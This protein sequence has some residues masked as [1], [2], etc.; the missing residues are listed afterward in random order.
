MKRSF[1]LLLALLLAIFVS[2]SYSQTRIVFLPFQNMDGNMNLN[3][4]CYKL[5]D[6]LAK[7]FH[8][9]D[10]EG[11][12]YRIIPS[13]SVKAQLAALKL[14]PTSPQYQ[15]DIWKVVEELKGTLVI[16]GNFLVKADRFLICAYIYDVE[17]KMPNQDFQARDLFVSEDK[18]FN[19]IPVI[20]RKLFTY[21][22]DGK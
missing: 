10:P 11:K 4:W 13:D 2:N 7:S 15:T 3:V 5:Q 22:S 18:I 9:K 19:T 14:D 12:L 1:V 17:T 6:S 16:S 8:D 20:T 21:F